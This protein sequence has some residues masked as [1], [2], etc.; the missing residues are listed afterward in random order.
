M[1]ERC[2]PQIPREIKQFTTEDII[3]L[4]RI[5]HRDCLKVKVLTDTALNTWPQISD[6]GSPIT[7]NPTV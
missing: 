1:K 4:R 6:G 3:C 5:W 7:G 2:K